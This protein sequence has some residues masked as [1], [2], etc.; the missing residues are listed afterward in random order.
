MGVR[1]PPRV[2]L[3]HRDRVAAADVQVPGVEAQADAAPGEHPGGLLAALD[4]RADMRVQGGDESAGG[5]GL[6]DAVKVAQ[7]GRPAG[8]VEDR[9]LVVALLTRCSGDDH[10]RCAGCDQTGHRAFDLR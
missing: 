6:G 8:L 3:R 4:H 7:E 5:C 2:L 1:D 10:R 9:A